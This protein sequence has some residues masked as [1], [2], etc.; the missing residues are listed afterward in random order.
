MIIF[1]ETSDEIF[2]AYKIEI[3]RKSVSSKIYGMGALPVGYNTNTTITEILLVLPIDRYQYVKD[4]ERSMYDPTSGFTNSSFNYKRTLYVCD[5]LDS[6]LTGAW[7]GS[8]EINEDNIIAK[9]S[10]DYYENGREFPELKHI[11][12]DRKIDELLK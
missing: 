3:E 11:Y 7:I 2:G 8:I 6:K 1:D 12:R 4:W 10:C 5:K 9:L